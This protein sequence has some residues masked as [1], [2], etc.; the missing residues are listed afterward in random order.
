MSKRIA[1]ASVAAALL[2]AGLI[3]LHVDQLT[4]ELWGGGRSTVVVVTGDLE[5]GHPLGADDLTTTDLPDRFVESRHIPAVRIDDLLSLRL[6]GPVKAGELLLLSDIAGMRAMDRTLSGLIADGT[7]AMPVRV[8]HMGFSRLL[9]PGDRVDVFVS[10]KRDSGMRTE[11][12]LENVLVLAVGNDLGAIQDERNQR[13][14]QVTL[15]VTPEQGHTLANAESDGVL[16][17][18]LRNPSDH[19]LR[20]QAHAG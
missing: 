17:L 20:E 10:R 14:G 7:R 8:A 5:V 4:R 19:L 2:G 15:N 12:L 3:K 11:T 1:L 9:R 18:V 13:G 16:R 6:A